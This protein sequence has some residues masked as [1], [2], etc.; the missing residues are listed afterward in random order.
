MHAM[1]QFGQVAHYGTATA[2][3]SLPV[4]ARRLNPQA[5]A[6]L[7]RFPLSPDGKV[8]LK[9]MP[10]SLMQEW[11]AE[12][13]EKPGVR[14]WPLPDGSPQATGG[15]SSRVCFETLNQAAV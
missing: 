12:L 4:D 15:P 10:R 14:E 8:L 1:P 5:A 9:A 13:K 2:A 7:P 3:A 6:G 11:V